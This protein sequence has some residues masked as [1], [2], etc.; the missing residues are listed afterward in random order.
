MNMKNTLNKRLIYSIR[1]AQD[2]LSKLD[3]KQKT[4]LEKAWDIEHAYYSST[5]EG[6]KLDRKEFEKLAQ[7]IT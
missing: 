5:L 1:I 4:K 3:P 6:S 7:K 2:E